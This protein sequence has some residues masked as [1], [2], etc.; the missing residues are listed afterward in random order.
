MFMRELIYFLFSIIGEERVFASKQIDTDL[1]DLKSDFA[2]VFGIEKLS[3]ISGSIVDNYRMYHYQEGINRHYAFSTL[4]GATASLVT[5]EVV[6]D[7]RVFFDNGI[8][9]YTPDPYYL[10]EK[11]FTRDSFIKYVSKI[12]TWTSSKKIQKRL[13]VLESF[14]KVI[15]YYVYTNVNGEASILDLTGIVCTLYKDTEYEKSMSFVKS[16][17]KHETEDKFLCSTYD[18]NDTTDHF[19]Y[20][21]S[22]C[23]Y[24]GSVNEKIRKLLGH[25]N[26]AIHPGT[27]DL[28]LIRVDNKSLLYS[29]KFDLIYNEF[30]LP[31]DIINVLNPDPSDYQHRTLILMLNH[32]VE[33]E[34]EEDILAFTPLSVTVP[35]QRGKY[36]QLPGHQVKS[37]KQIYGT[38]VIYTVTDNP[39]YIPEK[40]TPLED[41]DDEIQDVAAYYNEHNLPYIMTLMYMNE[42]NEFTLKELPV[43]SIPTSMYVSRKTGMI[44]FTFKQDVFYNVV[45]FFR[46]YYTL[47]KYS[48]ME[49]ATSGVREKMDRK[50]THKRLQQLKQHLIDTSSDDC[51]IVEEFNRM[52]NFVKVRIEENRSYE[53]PEK[54]N[55]I[56]SS[57]YF[58]DLSNNLINHDVNRV[59]IN[60]T[61]RF[62]DMKMIDNTV[63]S[64]LRYEDK[65]FDPDEMRKKIEEENKWL[66]EALKDFKI[67]T[68]G[69]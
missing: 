61:G 69:K 6:L 23:R 8:A 65:N 63:R 35:E 67:N 60:N 25:N 46:E 32:D 36:I 50:I 22:E 39:N 1:V 15:G 7:M 62:L 45:S 29:Y 64:R 13:E 14:K 20:I 52:H 54:R 59:F 43:S 48:Y 57:S 47:Y 42:N 49:I 11:G 40:E 26:F 28:F 68:G 37:M 56:I 41:Y 34:G 3:E 55:P 66:E 21:D 2:K 31:F 51:S 4:T 24:L 38:D 44:T 27:Y 17:I 9:F 30:D 12:Q 18:S 53:D 19:W 58:K 16:I 10:Q 5:D 33:R